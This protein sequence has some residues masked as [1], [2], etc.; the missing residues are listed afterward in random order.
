MRKTALG[1]SAIVIFSSVFIYYFL[2]AWEDQK[3]DQVKLQPAILDKNPEISTT[4]ENSKIDIDSAKF[5]IVAQ[6]L[7]IPWE[8]AFLPNNDLLVT[9][10]S[11]ELL[12]IGA[13]TKVIA[14]IEGV[15]HTS[16]G[17][18]LGL[19]LHP[20]FNENKYIYL[21]FTSTQNGKIINKVERYTFENDRISNKKV[22][23]D[24]I[25]GA[26]N[27]DGGRIAFGPDGYLYIT[28]G[29]AQEEGSAQDKNSLSGKIL[30]VTDE[31]S[32]PSDNPFGNEVWSYG[33][34]NPQGLAWDDEGTLWS[35]EHG[36]SGLGSGFDE[37]NRIEKGQNYGWPNVKGD[38]VGSEMAMPILHSGAR[39]TWAPADL[40]YLNGYLFFS[41]LR[42]SSLYSVYTREI[43][44]NLTRHF[45]DTY[46]RIRAV[47]AGPDGNLYFSTSNKDGRGI[48]KQNDDK[49]YK[50]ILK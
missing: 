23:V 20:N 28:T 29:D 26:A 16:E 46:G 44:F 17:G 40:A 13:D 37:L 32:V 5:E 39:D 10:R 34:R 36:P 7:N 35:T 41:G 6:N 42:G 31:G 4:N 49:I 50:I 15:N 2:L 19:A 27:H 33:H 47:V 14:E 12:R 3:T 25:A 1:L 18:L 11:G 48:P 38:E 8:I 45:E 43:K 9:Q 21:Y 24:S 30:R 22:I